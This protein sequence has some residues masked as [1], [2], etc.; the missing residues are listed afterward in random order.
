MT[1][2]PQEPRGLYS[3]KGLLLAVVYGVLVMLLLGGL[4][5][6]VVQKR[7]Y[8]QAQL[9]SHGQ[10]SAT[11]LGLSL[12]TVAVE[13]DWVA[14][15]S[16]IDAIFDSGAYSNVRLL[17]SQGQVVINRSALLSLEEVPDWFI[18]IMP[19]QTPLGQA[20]VVSGWK[21]VGTLQVRSHPGLAYRDLWST[22]KQQGALFVI[23]GCVVFLLLHLLLRQ[24]L[25]PLKRLESAA[26]KIAHRRFDVTLPLPATKEMRRV[27]EAVNTMTASIRTMFDEQVHTI[28][29]LRRT[30]LQD[31]VTGLINR[32]TFDKRL[33]AGLS[34]G[35]GE[36]SG[37][38]WLLELKGFGRYNEKY[39]RS[40]GDQLLTE[41]AE[42]LQDEVRAVVGSYVARH[43]GSSFAAFIP[44]FDLEHAGEL[45][46]QLLMRL[47]A[48]EALQKDGDCV[49]ALGMVL[50]RDGDNLSDLLSAAD[51]AAQEAVQSSGGGWSA[52][53]G[54]LK[55]SSDPVK[56]ASFWRELLREALDRQ[57]FVMNFQPVVSLGISEKNNGTNSISNEALPDV[58]RQGVIMQ[59]VLARLA[60]EHGQHAAAEFVPMLNR[61]AMTSE[62]DL[63]MLEQ[64]LHRLSQHP[65][66]GALCILLSVQTLARDDLAAVLTALLHK[67]EGETGRLYLECP[68]Y[69]LQV[70]WA[71]V[72][73]LIQLRQRFGYRLVIGRFGTAG[74]PFGYL[75]DLSVDAIKVDPGLVKNID[76]DDGH[77][78]YLRSIVQ[79]AHSQNS[80]VIAVGVESQEEWDC[81]MN[82]GVDGA[83]GY[84]ICHP[85]SEPV[86]LGG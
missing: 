68:E 55:R 43:A 51:F 14:A 19:L 27:T 63:C 31:S 85:Q 73:V 61:F 67:Y 35:A 36:G 7:E 13:G 20:D 41:V 71:G 22:V 12:S 16:M 23:L 46:D 4:I 38:L 60:D 40:S 6:N 69:A 34:S 24:L 45:A 80:L 15:S 28:E 64:G 37:V 50:C 5:L 44:A 84:H 77:Q 10:D 83:M 78:F 82:I 74:L 1:H 18:S 72:D 21:R 66:D 75:R 79:I 2:K 3:F 56:T 17:D 54:D 57:G 26:D 65:E 62:L 9:T 58:A 52:A 32:E 11:S 70:C 76:E 49:T 47:Q 33:Q 86:H 59:Q 53:D 29:S 48:L 25:R 81:L 42:V 30:A 39:G 8:L